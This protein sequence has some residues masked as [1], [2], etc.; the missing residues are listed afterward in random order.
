MSFDDHGPLGVSSVLANDRLFP[1][2]AKDRLLAT[3]A[4]HGIFSMVTDD[5]IGRLRR[6][7]KSAGAR[8]PPK[9]QRH[10][11]PQGS[12]RWL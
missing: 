3:V 10:G 7:A 2:D 6:A 4:S 1:V 8:V 12:I 5:G 9:K 11:L